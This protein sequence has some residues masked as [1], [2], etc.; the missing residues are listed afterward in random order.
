MQLLMS[1]RVRAA[2]RM[3]LQISFTWK[4]TNDTSP[5][6]EK[7]DLT[8]SKIK[9]TG[10]PEKKKKYK[11]RKQHCVSNVVVAVVSVSDQHTSRNES[12]KKIKTS[13]KGKRKNSKTRK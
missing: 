6:R 5:Q 10:K 13:H 2:A 11:E 12:H 7:K 8:K 3:V 4:P 9:S 1:F